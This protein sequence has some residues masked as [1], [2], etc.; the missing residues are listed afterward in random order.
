MTLLSFANICSVLAFFIR[1]PDNDKGKDPAIFSASVIHDVFGDSDD[2]EPAE[3][4]VQNQT[5]EKNR[6]PKYKGNYPEESR[7]GNVVPD[8]D[9]I[10]ECEEERTGTKLNRRGDAPPVVFEIPLHPPSVR[11]DQMATIKISNLIGIDPKPFDPNTF[12]KE[13]FFV[14]DASG[15]KRCIPPAN[16]IRWREVRNPDGTTSVE[17][18]ARFVTWS[19][20]SL[21]LLIGNEAFN[22]SEQD[23][24]DI[25]SHLFLRHA[26]GIYQSQGRISRKMK[27]MPSSLSS[28]SHR[29]LTALV[30][31]RHKKVNKVRQY[32]TDVDPERMM[33]QEEKVERQTI[34]ASKQLNEKKKKVIDK[35]RPKGRTERQLTPGFLE[36]AIDKDNEQNYYEAPNAAT[37]HHFDL[38]LEMEAAAEKRI[39]DA[40]KGPKDTHKSAS[41]SVKFTR[42]S[43][44]LSKLDKV[45]LEHGFKGDE[46][47]GTISHRKVEEMQEGEEEEPY[48]DSEVEAEGPKGKRKESG[49]NLRKQYIESDEDT[50]PMRT[51]T[52][53]QI[54]I[55]YDSNEE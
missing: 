3:Y 33:E 43:L 48:E 16:I 36:D 26:K 12:V 49:S 4:A 28:N 37:L 11:P 18:N 2:D 27:F 40:K 22:V 8:E 6:S 34:K 54:A 53:R 35:Y 30:D 9:A 42:P 20:G 17:S 19:D 32:I 46:V 14:T 50:P 39:M 45:K 15:S 38:D 29:C 52:R 25:Q 10:Y 41:S 51:A 21:Q 47:E 1:S 44:H 13:D 5:N 23:A 55:M 31:S 24:Q 7:V